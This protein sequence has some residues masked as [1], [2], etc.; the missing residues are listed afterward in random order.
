M[1]N[2]TQTFEVKKI[3]VEYRAYYNTETKQIVKIVTVE[4]NVIMNPEDLTD[5]LKFIV[6]DRNQIHVDLTNHIID[7][8]QIIQK[9]VPK[10]DDL[11][12]EKTFDAAQFRTLTNN[13]IFIVDKSF[14]GNTSSW[15][16]KTN[17]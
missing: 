13:N 9:P 15:R 4:N 16:I 11:K 3:T 6:I 8:N 12:L 2:N 17:E 7:N 10:I 5:E 14:T 1:N